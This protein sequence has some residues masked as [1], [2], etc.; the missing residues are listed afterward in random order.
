MRQSESGV[1]SFKFGTEDQADG[2]LAYGYK[3]YETHLEEIRKAIKKKIKKNKKKK[4]KIPAHKIKIN[5]LYVSYHE[6][7]KYIVRQNM[8]QGYDFKC[9]HITNMSCLIDFNMDLSKYQVQLQ[10]DV[11]INWVFS[12]ILSQHSGKCHKK[13]IF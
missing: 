8:V 7:A 4:H 12:Y 1:K 11:H 9:G 6:Q 5:I 3:A 10:D 2:Y 13:C